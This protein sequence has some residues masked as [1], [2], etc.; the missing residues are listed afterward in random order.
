[1]YAA[2]TEEYNSQN[3]RL[4]IGT[5]QERPPHIDM[6]GVAC[7]ILGGGEGKRLFPL[8]HSCCKPAISFGGR[9]RLIDVPISSQ[10][11]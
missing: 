1:M 8:T 9:Y 7:I 4:A 11:P 10:L 6:R 5:T 3:E 2:K